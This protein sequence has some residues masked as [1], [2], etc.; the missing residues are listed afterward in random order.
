MDSEENAIEENRRLRRTMRDLVALSTLPAVW[1]G[2]GLER[3]A[4]SLADVLLHTLSLDLIYIR[5][6]GLT[7]EGPIEIVR[8]K[9]HIDAAHDEAVRAAFAPQLSD[10]SEP[11]TTIPDPFG[12]GVLNVAVTRFGVGDDSGI[13][14]TGSRNPA[15]P[16][17]Q[18]RL[19]LSVGAN[20]TAIV[21][22]RRRAEEQVRQ[23]QE[24]LRVTLA[25]IGDAVITT[26]TQGRVTFLNGVAQEMTGWTLAEAEGQSLEAV[27]PIINEQT[28]KVVRNPVENVLKEGVIVGLANHTILLARDGTERPIDDS[29]AP[30]RDGSGL[31]IGV[32]LVFRDVT[33]QRRAEHE[34]RASEARKSAI[35]ETAMDCIITMD[36]NGKVVEFNP[37]AE[38]TFGY[39]RD[40]VVGRE[41]AD[42]IIPPSL[43]DQHRRG[44]T[45]YLTTGEGPVLGKRIELP[46]QRADGNEFPVE[47][48]ITRIPTDGPPLFTAYLRDISERTRAERYRNARLGVTQVLNQASD[49]QEGASR[50]LQVVCESLDWDV[51]FFWIVNKGG[52][53]LK[54]LQ[55][56]HKPDL[57]ATEFEEASFC[58]EFKKGEGL[59]GHVWSTGKPCW[60][61]DVVCAPNFPRAASAAKD[62]LHS[63]FA[64]PVV[65]GDRM[66]GVIEF[67]TRRIQEPDAD[68]LEMMGT[69]AG[70][71]GQFIERQTAEQE[72]R[73][74]EA[75]LA[76]FFENATVGLHW[77]GVDGTILRANRAEL[78]MLGYSREEY[79]GR[80]IA[81]FHA[82]KDAICDI[83]KRLQAGEKLEEYPARLRCKDGAIRNVVIDSSVM[84]RDGQFVHTRCFT[85]DVTERKRVEKEL[86]DSEQ[87]FARFMQYLP[88][89]AWIKDVQGRYVYANDAAEKAFRTARAELYGKTDKEVFPS[90]TAAQFQRNDKQA[91]SS[92]TGVQVVE[93]LEQENEVRHSLVS[94]FPILGSDGQVALIGGMAIDIT[95]QR[96]VEQ[97]LRHSEERFRNL[98]EQA[99]F[100][101]QVFSPD[102]HTSRVNRAWEQLWGVTLDQIDGY[103]ILEDQQL[104]AKGV[105]PLIHQAFAGEPT[106]IPAIKYDPNETIPGQTRHDDPVRWVAA[107]AYP[108]KDDAGIIQEVVL[109][110][111]DITARRKAEA[112]LRES[113]EK[114][115]LLAD[116][117]PQLAWMAR[118]DGHIF[119][120]NRRWYE[121]T[122]TTPAQMEGWGWQSVHDPDVLPKVLDRWK[123]SIASGEPFDMVFPLKGADGQ[124]RPFLTRVNP[125][126]N[127]GGQILYWFGTNTD[128]AELREA[129]EALA[130][131]EERLRL[132]LDAGRMGVWDWNIRT[133]DLKWSDSLEPLHGLAP[134][135]FGG[136]FDHFQQ[137]IHPKDRESVNAAIR[138]ALDTGGEFYVEFRNVWQNGGIH[139]IA[140]SGKVFPGDDGQPLRMIGIGLDVTQRKRSE[141]T[142]R[143]LADASAALAV[144]VDFDST[145]QT[146]SSLAVPHFA[147]WATVDVAEAD[148][149]LRRVAVAHVD[150]A[151]VE[152][153]HELHRRFPPDPAATQGGWNILRTGQPEI[154]HKITDDL[155]VQTVRDQERLGIVRQLGLRSY[156]GVPLTMRGKTIG[157]LTFIA[158]ESGHLYDAT[159]L[160]VAEDLASRAAI[161]I[162]NAQLY[163]EL[164]DAD[165]RKDE[166]LATLAHELRNPLAPIRNGLQVL[167]LANAD[168]GMVDKARSMMERQLSQMVRLVDDLLDVSRI[169]RNKLELRKERVSLKSVINS[170]VETSHPL[171]EKASHTFSIT[172]PP[173]PVYLDADLTRLAQVFSN[174][175]NNAAKYTEP[176]GRIL[177]TGEL[178]GAE[179]V[180]QVQDNGRGI[181]ADAL[182]HIFEM[183]SQVDRNLE[184]AQGG[185]GIG[186]TLV[187]RLVE[188]HGGTVEAK[189]DGHG[190]GSTF[191]V[192]LPV[193]AV[194]VANAQE[195][196]DEA[197]A[198]HA[199][200]RKVLVVDDNRDSAESLG[201]MLKLMG[202][203]V[204]TAHDGLEAVE[205]ASQ[206]S[207]DLILMDVGM[208]KL[209][210]F[211]ATRRI[212]EQPWGKDVRIVVLTGW[213]QEEDRRMSQEAGCDGHM[214]KPVDPAALEK[215]LETLREK[216]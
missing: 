127:E 173:T 125:L 13:L 88:G 97:A 141:Q 65:V 121:Y 207:P 124:F 113:E 131:S 43:R 10:W 203:E 148:G 117:I 133:G 172:L 75:E 136:T 108:L 81:D 202:N 42:F 2:L 171:I 38:R 99:P 25:S 106:F 62:G 185:L 96:R 66:I 19:L 33:E 130:V 4:R 67:F 169:T 200:K 164:R 115:R 209:N 20:Q 37:A 6:T 186:L 162:E 53:S 158:A 87:R 18:D 198:R 91:M 76:D 86:R 129:R 61:L 144:L 59:P 205:A 31:M 45:H 151:K 39:S 212:R 50:V 84:F 3:I 177:L 147:D 14:V 182:P 32:V 167:R 196:R 137:L 163:R 181:P 178:S 69:A 132:A 194:P 197:G 157:V 72:L 135:T 204:R 126:T 138:Q 48:A 83:L 9:H 1:T 152:L 216:L 80:P 184:R 21:I 155:L 112:A 143:F 176:G 27:F 175:L 16:T 93:I 160:A 153:A 24:W 149:T 90:E 103:N 57:R 52:D 145:L 123:G 71:F 74:S 101:I 111:D 100:S 98:M 166:F 188:M 85:R 168:G 60:L 73:Y 192:R 15:F 206:F 208:P 34:L 47:L 63:A 146:V 120:Y 191:V 68:L 56:W 156:I 165:Q 29:A 150:P 94:K 183:F 179:V 114:L 109:V 199:A 195:R 215:L 36:H 213:G 41:L 17:E 211:D 189:S 26:D 70:N 139:W 116:T 119:W 104:E 40:E 46:A 55:N 122:G 44:M 51:G 58:R 180:V 7:S 35:L 89:L 193:V 77:V 30:I 154:I 105:L 95:E 187:R 210:G 174:L 161:A 49:V 128:I 142:A 110:H 78:D 54:C 12:S 107:V 23:Q 28:R 11:P 190:K 214:V 201:M 140:G 102:G 79:V 170:A 64:C 22:Q 92:G 134:G 82:D 5:L 118:P 159:D 8:S